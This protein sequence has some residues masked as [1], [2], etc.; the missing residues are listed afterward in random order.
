MGVNRIN[1][2]N[3]LEEKEMFFIESIRSICDYQVPPPAARRPAGQQLSA[4][5]RRRTEMPPWHERRKKKGRPGQQQ[6]E[7][8]VIREKLREHIYPG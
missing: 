4:R 3:L 1:S 5:D 2:M 7:T 8:K 6:R